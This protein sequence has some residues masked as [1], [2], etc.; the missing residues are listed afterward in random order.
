MGSAAGAS[1]TKPDSTEDSEDMS[2]EGEDS[3]ECE[4]IVTGRMEDER[5]RPSRLRGSLSGYLVMVF[6]SVRFRASSK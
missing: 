5:T 3:G 1:G 2:Q 6:I 4:V